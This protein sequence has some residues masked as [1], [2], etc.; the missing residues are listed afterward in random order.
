MSYNIQVS[1]QFKKEAKRLTKKYP[2]LKKELKEMSLSLSENPFQG[3]HLGSDVYKPRISIASK[4]KGKSGGGRVIHYVQLDDE[5]V[6]LLTIY[7]KGEKSSI[8]KEE[9]EAILQEFR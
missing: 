1:S 5:N 2:S 3:V 7:N 6:I 9:I 8:T 4:G